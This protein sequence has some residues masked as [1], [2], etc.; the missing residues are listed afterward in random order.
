MTPGDPW[1]LL[2]NKCIHY[3]AN[4]EAETGSDSTTCEREHNVHAGLTKTF[5]LVVKVGWGFFFLVLC[6]HC[7]SF[8]HHKTWQTLQGVK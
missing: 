4:T 3:P 5:R 6:G 1:T 2:K 7:G 8:S